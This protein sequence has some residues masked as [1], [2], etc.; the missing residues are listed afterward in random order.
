[1]KFPARKRTLMTILMA[2]GAAATSAAW[3]APP[4]PCRV[5][6]FADA[7]LSDREALLARRCGG[8]N[9]DW[10]IETPRAKPTDVGPSQVRSRVETST[11]ETLGGGLKTSVRMSWAGLRTE[12]EP[13]LR[14][15]QARIA[16]GAQ[17]RLA[18][19][20]AL[21]MNLGRDVA[22][23]PRNRATLSSVWQP[24][25]SA[26]LY[27]EW[28]GTGLST[29]ETEVNRVGARW[30]LVPRRLSFD[31]GTAQRPGVPGWEDP[32]FA[33]TWDISNLLR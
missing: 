6:P 2:G 26:T 13:G 4:V 1:M 27:A 16:A 5:A 11:T 8:D 28:V 3:A 31:L 29:S 7:G 20:W 12:T 24:L 33:V 15:E 22:G 14:T 30:W 18:D 32:R 9:I 10:N 19:S 17:V 25:R 23:V 21:Q